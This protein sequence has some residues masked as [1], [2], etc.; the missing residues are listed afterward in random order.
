MTYTRRS[1]YI[2]RGARS[3][4][5]IQHHNGETPDQ[6]VGAHAARWTHPKPHVADSKCN[7]DSLHVESMVA[8]LWVHRARSSNGYSQ[9]GAH[10]LQQSHAAAAQCRTKHALDRMASAAC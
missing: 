5:S 3:R 10:D 9:L 6:R 2:E 8:G 1:D 7:I 4:W